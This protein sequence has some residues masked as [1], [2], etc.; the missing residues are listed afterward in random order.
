MRFEKNVNRQKR[1][2][3]KIVNKQMMKVSILMNI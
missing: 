2:Y 1:A 3:I